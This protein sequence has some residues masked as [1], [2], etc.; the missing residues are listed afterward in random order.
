M[1]NDA[2]PWQP[3]P[4]LEE[5]NSARSQ[6]RRQAIRTAEG[7]VKKVPALPYEYWCKPCGNVVRLVVMTTRNVRDAIEPQ[8]YADFTRRRAIRADWFPWEYAEAERYVPALSHG[9]GPA[10][11]D[12]W[13]HEEQERRWA[14]HRERAAQYGQVYKEDEIRRAMQT[15]EALTGAI[16]EMVTLMRA[17][18]NKPST[19]VINVAGKSDDT[20]K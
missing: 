1:S 18:A 9:M 3:V 12:K 19:T 16:S 20:K 7:K 6:R 5:Y 15:K 2:P 8:R 11:W 14:E 4:A 17:D 10:A 13:R